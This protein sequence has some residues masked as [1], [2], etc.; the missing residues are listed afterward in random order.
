MLVALML[1]GHHTSELMTL[2]DTPISGQSTE[3]KLASEQWRR[4]QEKIT[5][6]AA[7][8][9]DRIDLDLVFLNPSPHM[10][11][12][13]PTAEDRGD[14]HKTGVAQKITQLPALSGILRCTDIYGNAYALAVIEGRRFRENEQVREYTIQKIDDQGVVLAKGGRRWF[15]RSPEVPYSYNYEP[16]A[17]G[18]GP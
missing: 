3:V 14:G 13:T 16:D 17:Q 4:L 12:Q 7:K 11:H 5:Q 6:T 1:V 9:M 10:R 15:L 8:R 18:S 2:L